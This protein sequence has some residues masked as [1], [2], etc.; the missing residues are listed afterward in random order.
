MTNPLHIDFLSERYLMELLGLS[1]EAKADVAHLAELRRH[2]LPFV[3]L[4]RRVRVYP[5]EE[6][7]AWFTK[8]RW[9]G[10]LSEE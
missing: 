2:G 8:K 9:K 7:A 4:S 10:G 1:P 6:L 3:R 5:R